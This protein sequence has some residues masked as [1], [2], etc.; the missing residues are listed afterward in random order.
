M[1]TKIKL[2]RHV[3]VGLYAVEIESVADHSASSFVFRV[4]GQDK[5]L[6][7]KQPPDFMAYMQN[8]LVPASALMEAVLAFHRAQNLALESDPL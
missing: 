8:Q 2:I 4:E 1:A 3:E 5:V 7:V 6:V